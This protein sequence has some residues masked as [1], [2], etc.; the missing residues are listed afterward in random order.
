MDSITN[1]MAKPVPKVGGRGQGR[2]CEGFSNSLV[3]LLWRG[4]THTTNSQKQTAL[5]TFSTDFIILYG[6]FVCIFML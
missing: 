4:R 6:L 2:L 5:I 1:E 3:S